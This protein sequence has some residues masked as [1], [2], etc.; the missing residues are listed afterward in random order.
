MNLNFFFVVLTCNLAR[1]FF[2]LGRYKKER[3]EGGILREQKLQA[4]S[5]FGFPNE[6]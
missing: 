1:G 2:K 6:N 3:T 5:F 4:L